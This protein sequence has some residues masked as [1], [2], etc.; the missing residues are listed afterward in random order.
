[1]DQ[2]QPLGVTMRLAESAC[3]QYD[4]KGSISKHTCAKQ[5]QTVC[6]T[7]IVMYP[8]RPCWHKFFI[9]AHM[10][11]T[12]MPYDTIVSR[13]TCYH[14]RSGTQQCSSRS[15]ATWAVQSSCVGMA[16]NKLAN[17]VPCQTWEQGLMMSAPVPAQLSIEHQ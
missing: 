1:M 8:L 12:E 9:A 13:D 7:P 17:S 10:I 6:V 15:A 5:G 16:T 3:L 4:N 14:V 11:H 2:L